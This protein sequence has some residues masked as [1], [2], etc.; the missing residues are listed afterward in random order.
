MTAHV[1]LSNIDKERELA[2]KNDLRHRML[3]L[4]IQHVTIETE[5]EG[6]PAKE[7]NCK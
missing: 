4:N 7:S 3:H 5:T 1:V 2:I 6:V